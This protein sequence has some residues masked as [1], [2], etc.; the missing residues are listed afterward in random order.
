MHRGIFLF[1][2]YYILQA[3]F[4]AFTTGA[5]AADSSLTHAPTAIPFYFLSNG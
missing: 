2:Y 3:V 5:E 1:V 4:S